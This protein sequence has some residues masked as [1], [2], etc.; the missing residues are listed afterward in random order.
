MGYG[1]QPLRHPK[2]VDKYKFVICRKV[3]LIS[4]N[5]AKEENMLNINKFMIRVCSVHLQIHD[6]SLFVGDVI[7]KN[8]NKKK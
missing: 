4:R 7:V 2:R 8:K 6:K 1:G 3:G 5:E